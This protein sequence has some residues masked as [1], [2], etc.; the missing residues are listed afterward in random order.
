MSALQTLFQDY[1]LTTLRAAD[2]TQLED[3]EIVSRRSWLPAP[4][5][6]IPY[7]I[8]IHPAGNE[9]EAIGTNE[10]D[11]I[12][13]PF[14]LTM[15]S[16]ADSD[17]ESERDTINSWRQKSRRIFNNVR[18]TG[19]TET[20]T[21]ILNSR[22]RMGTINEKLPKDAYRYDLSRMVVVCWARETRTP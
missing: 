17:M 10:R 13:Y 15:A 16:H 19:I 11:E 12:G 1:L 9:P 3:E 18:P 7:G 4:D 5:G 21:S 22:V 6:P 14:Y 20:G 8:V 2:L